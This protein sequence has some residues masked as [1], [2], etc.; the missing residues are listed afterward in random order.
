MP[1]ARR[2]GARPGLSWLAV[3]L[4]CALAAAAV[5]CMG[6]AAS[7]ATQAP[8]LTASSPA[9]DPIWEPVQGSRPA[10]SLQSGDENG[11]SAQH[12]TRRHMAGG[13]EETLLIG[14]AESERF[15]RLDVLRGA[16]GPDP[17]NLSVDLVRRAAASGATV[18]RIGQ[19]SSVE[20]KFGTVE[21]APALLSAGVERSCLA[22]RF[23]HGDLSFRLHGFVCSSPERRTSAQELAC[24]LDAL[25]YAGGTD[26]PALGV[27]FAQADKRRAADCLPAVRDVAAR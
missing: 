24:F 26:D 16:V 1:S 3:S 7:R 11:I 8:A 13:R 27:L 5:A 23:S 20:T 14:T 12:A 4:L 19:S 21:A 18:L 25:A 6:T 22:F 15:A 17:A 10:Y 9:T 2:S